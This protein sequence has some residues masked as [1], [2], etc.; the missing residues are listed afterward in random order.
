[1]TKVLLIVVLGFV[2]LGILITC[3]R[4][5]VYM[6]VGIGAFI[7]H[8]VLYGCYYWFMY[9][10]S[11]VYCKTRDKILDRK[12]PDEGAY[13]IRFGKQDKKGKSKVRFVS[14]R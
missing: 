6:I 10:V 14:T 9:G 13:Y 8:R 2:A 12:Y 4:Y 1:M 5:I 3:I 7:L 11:F